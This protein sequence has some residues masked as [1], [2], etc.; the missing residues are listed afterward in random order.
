M[1]IRFI[2]FFTLYFSAFTATALAPVYIEGQV[3]LQEAPDKMELV[4][5][6]VLARETTHITEFQPT[7]NSFATSLELSPG[8]YQLKYNKEEVW[9]ALHPGDSIQVI[10]TEK[11]PVFVSGSSDTRELEKYEAYRKRSFDQ[12]VK[13]VRD[14]MRDAVSSRDQQK[15]EFLALQEHEN[16]QEHL[17]VLMDY[18]QKMPDTSLAIYYTALRWVGDEYIDFLQN[19]MQRFS[20]HY[21]QLEL[22]HQMQQK[23]DQL[24]KVAIGAKAPE[25]LLNDTLYDFSKGTLT[26][27]EFWAS[28]CMPCRRANPHLKELYESYHPKG[29]NLLGISL[30]YKASAMEKAVVADGISWPVF[31]DEKVY[32]SP[33]AQA[34]NISAIP[35]NF[36]INSDG[37]IVAKNLHWQKLDGLLRK[38]LTSER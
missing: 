11:N 32:N 25:V 1:S 12:L 38:Q 33:L 20:L 7:N 14:E 28:W 35:S 23:V 6:D 19:L 18:V 17:H 16:Y 5:W 31:T 30:D 3:Q 22:T 8:L 2:F 27:V 21:P 34:Y 29:F 36:L 10:I 15:I 26:L 37:I 9:L 13:V 24:A 4:Q